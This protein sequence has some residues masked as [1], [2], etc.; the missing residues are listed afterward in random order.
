MSR[1]AKEGDG[2]ACRGSQCP[3]F[4][5]LRSPYRSMVAGGPGE[6]AWPHLGASQ[7]WMLRLQ[8]LWGKCLGF[9]FISSNKIGARMLQAD[10]CT[11]IL[12]PWADNSRGSGYSFG[13][14]RG[15]QGKEA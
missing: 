12:P 5:E 1:A 15:E 2:Q 9:S 11:F 8:E 14:P 13:R 6:V 7:P 10:T 3:L 4:V